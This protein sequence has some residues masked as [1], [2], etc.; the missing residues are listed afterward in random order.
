MLVRSNR[1]PAHDAE[2]RQEG[3]EQENSGS[4]L[5]GPASTV[6]TI[7]FSFTI[8]FS[9]SFPSCTFTFSAKVSYL[10]FLHTYCMRLGHYFLLY[11]RS[12]SI[13]RTDYA[14]SSMMPQPLLI[15]VLT[16]SVGL[17]VFYAMGIYRN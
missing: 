5:G 6:G 3:Q 7:A 10:Y 2:A 16:L 14:Y 4:Y 8:F 11:L 12:S 17:S 15:P 1:P 9:S 13:Y